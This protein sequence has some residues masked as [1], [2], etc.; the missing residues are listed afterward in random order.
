MFSPILFYHIISLILSISVHNYLMHLQVK[1]LTLLCIYLS[2]SREYHYYLIS[3]CSL[4]CL[5]LEK[6]TTSLIPINL[7]AFTLH[8]QLLVFPSFHSQ[9]DLN[10]TFNNVLR[11]FLA[12]TLS[13]LT[14]KS[15]PFSQ[16]FLRFQF[17]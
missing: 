17:D 14:L 16:I 6:K 11:N 1:F 4:P 8:L 9:Q 10:V 7:S 15:T 12:S 2:I 5:L 13:L 3:C